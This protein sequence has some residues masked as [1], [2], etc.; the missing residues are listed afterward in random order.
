VGHAIA[1]VRD[2]G[3]VIHPGV[4]SQEGTGFILWRAADI[5]PAL[6][7]S[8]RLAVLAAC[9]TGKSYRSRRENHGALV[10]AMLSAGVTNVVASRWDVDSVQTAV[11][12]KRFYA[13]LLAGDSSVAAARDSTLQFIREPAR[14]HPYYWAAFAVFG[15]E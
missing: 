14:S 1:N 8:C 13:A 3:L 10:R 4:H 9:S 11:Y 15:H 12:S 2:E 6:F 5:S 7:R